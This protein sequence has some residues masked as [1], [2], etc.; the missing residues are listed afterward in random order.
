MEERMREFLEELTHVS[1]A[2][3]FRVGACGCCNS[4]WVLELKSEDAEGYYTVDD[5]GE[6]LDWHVPD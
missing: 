2:F 5:D 4:P 3:G 6:G 1:R